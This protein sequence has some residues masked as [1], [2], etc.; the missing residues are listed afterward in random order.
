MSSKGTGI[1]TKEN[2]DTLLKELAKEFKRLN[3]TAVAAEIILISGAAILAGYG[4]REMTMDV[5][6]VIHAS[7]TMKE[8]ANRVGHKSNPPM[9]G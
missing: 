7:A 5:D 3:G 2:L 1:F 9:D 6:A 4:F 8:A